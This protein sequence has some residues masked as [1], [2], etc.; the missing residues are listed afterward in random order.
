MKTHG[1]TDDFPH[2]LSRRTIYG[3]FQ[4]GETDMEQSY[5]TARRKLL[6]RRLWLIWAC[7]FLSGGICG[8]LAALWFSR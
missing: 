8:A 5:A 7:A 4:A 2:A 6:S 3:P 1:Y